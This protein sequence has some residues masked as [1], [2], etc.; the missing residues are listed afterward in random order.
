MEVRNREQLGLA[1]DQPLACRC[2]LALRTMPVAAAVVADDGV[3]A[4]SVLA[5]R[6]MAA[7]RRCSAAFDRRHHLHLAEADVPRVGATPR[8][9]VVAE[10]VRTL[11][12]WTLH[13][14]RPLRRRL[15]LATS[16]GPLTWVLG[17]RLGKLP[18]L[19]ERAH[20]AGDHAGRNT[21]VARRRLQL[22]VSEKRLDCTNI[23]P[24]IEQMRR[25]AVPQ[26]VQVHRL[27][28]PG[29]IRCLVEQPVDL[30]RRPR[31]TRLAAW[32]QQAILRRHHRVP[33]CRSRLPPLPQQAERLR[34]QHHN[35]I[36]PALRLLDANDVLRAVDMLHPQP[37]YLARS[38]ARAIAQT[39]QKAV[40]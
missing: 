37:G 33:T 36:L 8:G 13:D 18:Q 3:P 23:H 15:T 31:L 5:A 38:Q 30:P 29:R 11:Q 6:N 2:P 19:V 25:K 26:R 27:L 39:E 17:R 1:L 12:S 32:K 14:P 28:D 4:R 10:D 22:V 20:D 40:P 7:E 16:S 35:P 24:A 21:R 34:P 9:A